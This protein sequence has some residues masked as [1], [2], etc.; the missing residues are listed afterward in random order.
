MNRAGCPL[1]QTSEAQTWEAQ[2]LA[3]V[4]Q[5]LLKWIQ[6]AGLGL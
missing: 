4:S 2:I 5:R 3:T 1:T 6:R